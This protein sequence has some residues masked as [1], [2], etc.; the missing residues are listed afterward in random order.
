MGKRFTRLTVIAD[1]E[2][3]KTG[4][5]QY[6]CQCD[7]GNTIILPTG[8]LTSG[9]TKSCGCL[10]K[11]TDKNRW[12]GSNNPKYGHGENMKGKN[13]PNYKHGLSKTKPYEAYTASIRRQRRKDQV[14]LSFDIEKINLIYQVCNAMNKEGHEVY[15]VDHIKPLSKG[16]LNDQNNLQILTRH[17]NAEKYSKW[18]LNE[19]EKIK[20][21]GITLIDIEKGGDYNFM[22]R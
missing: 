9:N 1:A 10:R 8:T 13:H 15:V 20:Y 11:E 3:D 5:L 18:P 19:D 6:L 12:L 7:C 4:H 2:K 16:G 21:T 17:L 22:P 14:S